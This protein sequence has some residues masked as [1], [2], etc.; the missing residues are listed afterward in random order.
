MASWGF[1]RRIPLLPL[2]LGITDGILNALTL[3]AGTILRGGGDGLTVVFALRVGVAA[4]VTAAF[5]MF[6]ADYSERRAAL[7]RAS[8]QLNMIEPRLASTRLGRQAVRDSAIAM[9]VAGLSSLIG[10]ALPL[11]A[12]A[13]IP[14]PSWIVLALTIAVLGVL[15]WLLGAILAGRRVVWATAMVIGGCIVTVIGA[16]L[17]IT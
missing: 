4:L 6:V 5:T 16:W 11:I 17:R 7:V 1:A 12:G 9:A 3:A 2:V 13:V 15:G 14:G 8:R 10:A